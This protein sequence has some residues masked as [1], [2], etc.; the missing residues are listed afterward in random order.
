MTLS[1]LR[2]AP[3]NVRPQS[4]AAYDSG[5]AFQWWYFD[6][7]LASGHRLLT[8]YTMNAPGIETFGLNLVLRAPDGTLVKDPRYFPKSAFVPDAGTFGGWFGE[9]SEAHFEPSGNGGLGVYRLSARGERIRYELDVLPDAPPF[10]PL[11]DEGELPS[12]LIAGS[13]LLG[14]GRDLLRRDRFRY[15]RFVPRGRLRGTIWC[16][17]IPIDAVG[18]VYHEH[19]MYTFPMGHVSSAWFWLHVANEEWSLIS[20]SLVAPGLEYGHSPFAKETFGGYVYALRGRERLMSTID[21]SGA[22]V[23]WRRVRMRDPRA[24]G[25]M[26]MAWGLD[27]VFRR[28]GLAIEVDVDSHDEL[29]YFSIDPTPED[30]PFWGQTVARAKVTVTEYGP[31][32]RSRTRFV[33]DAVLETMR[34]ARVGGTAPRFGR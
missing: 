12:A 21:F 24:R 23:N 34:N 15:T 29:E 27:A 9:G 18:R 8:F 22:L 7:Q 16:D 25:R 3:E 19:G 6:S 13:K 1:R 14:G 28:P 10:S 31:F 32:S 33:A 5:A 17:G 30:E 20:G 4:D 11:G 2:F 26:S